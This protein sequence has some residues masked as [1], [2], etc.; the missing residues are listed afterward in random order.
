MLVTFMLTCYNQAKFIRDAVRGGLAQD[1]QPLEVLIF[2]NHSTDGTLEIVREEIARYTGPHTVR[3]LTK[4]ENIGL[5][6]LRRRASKQPAERSSS[7]RTETTYLFPG[8]TAALVKV[9]QSTGA[10]LLASNCNIIDEQSQ[11][12]RRAQSRM[13]NRSVSRL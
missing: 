2:D 8:R 13:A 1:Y 12:I 7:A 3:L 10:S 9:W 6:V 11:V 5:E 4:S